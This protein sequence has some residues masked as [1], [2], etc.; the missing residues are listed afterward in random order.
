MSA[1]N[2]V[3]MDIR[4]FIRPDTTSLQP[5]SIHFRRSA[6]SG[7]YVVLNRRLG[8]SHVGRAKALLLSS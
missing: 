1:V 3:N 4:I 8:R 5:Q 2:A 7:F 6:V